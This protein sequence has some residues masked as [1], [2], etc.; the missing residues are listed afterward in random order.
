MRKIFTLLAVTVA[1]TA[2]AQKRPFTSN[3][4][5]DNWSIGINVGAT[6]ATHNLGFGPAY[7]AE[8]FFTE[9]GYRINNPKSFWQRA[10]FAGG[11]EIA[12]QWTPYIASV[13][14]GQA[15]INT[16]KSQTF[17]DRWSISYANRFNLSNLFFG[18]NGK[19]R[20][21]EVQA[22]AGVGMASWIA[23]NYEG[24]EEDQNGVLFSV[25]RKDDHYL[26]ARFGLSF[27]FNLGQKRAW[28]FS[29]KP[30]IVYNLDQELFQGK[31]DFGHLYQGATFNINDTE[32]EVLAG[33]TY[34]FRNA[35]GE[36]Y[37]TNVREYDQAEIDALNAK[38]NGLR[39]QLDGKD[40]QIAALGAEVA[41]LRE[42]GRAHV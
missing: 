1:L 19:P 29:I 33:L 8:R 6:A 30:S 14:T 26:F 31:R 2:T 18:Y 7:A 37:F 16:S 4:F 13:I 41:D 5:F 34:H 40:A 36:H 35:N 28:T 11:I 17:F 42:I 21:F 10:R 9:E 24:D 3:G 39:N 38:I 25:D 12:K 27:D 22:L 15:D 23:P 32:I 20:F